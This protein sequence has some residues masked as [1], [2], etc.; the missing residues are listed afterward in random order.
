MRVALRLFHVD[1]L[2]SDLILLSSCK[3]S[4]ATLSHLDASSLSAHS[5]LDL[6]GT[7]VSRS[8]ATSF[9][10]PITVSI[11]AFSMVLPAVELYTSYVPVTIWLAK[12]TNVIRL[13]ARPIAV[14]GSIIPPVVQRREL[15]VMLRTVTTLEQEEEMKVWQTVDGKCISSVRLSS[16]VAMGEHSPLSPQSTSMRRRGSIRSSSCTEY[17]DGLTSRRSYSTALSYMQRRSAWRPF[18]QRMSSRTASGRMNGLLYAPSV[19]NTVLGLSLILKKS[20]SPRGAYTLHSPP[21]S[22]LIHII[23]LVDIHE[24]IPASTM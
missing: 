2:P 7:S 1:W 14:I 16:L 23:A 13:D 11:C 15:A 12:S 22:N 20:D 5:C 17:R 10:S 9:R 19:P 8:A 3:R 21:A 24:S 18:R 4:F 6:P